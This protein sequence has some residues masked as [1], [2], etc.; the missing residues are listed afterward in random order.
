V[1]CWRKTREK[2]PPQEIKMDHFSWV[3]KTLQA[4]VDEDTFAKFHRLLD[5]C[6]IN[7]MLGNDLLTLILSMVPPR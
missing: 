1:V 7:D 3:L 2:A 5:L 4:E 6:P